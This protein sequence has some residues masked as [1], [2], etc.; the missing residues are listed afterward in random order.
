MDAD[1]FDTLVQQLGLLGTR[2]RTLGAL[3]GGALTLR[4]LAVPGDVAA[5]SGKC[6]SAC[7]ECETC[8]KGK[9]KKQNGKTHCKRGTCK[10]KP[11]GTACSSGRVCQGGSCV[12][13]SGT[14]FC[15]PGCGC[16]VTITPVSG[17]PRGRQ[18]T[19]SSECCGGGT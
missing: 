18:C 12:C 15:G 14:E 2:R 6:R 1:R 10:P 11:D 5:R 4:G 16:C 7:D 17:G 13:V 19:A 3:L 9:C 8:K